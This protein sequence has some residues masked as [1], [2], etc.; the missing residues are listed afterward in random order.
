MKEENTQQAR[1]SECVLVLVNWDRKFFSS[2]YG[3]TFVK[4]P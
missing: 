2:E 3:V 1:T 4:L